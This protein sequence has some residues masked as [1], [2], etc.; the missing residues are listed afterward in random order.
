MEKNRP[1]LFF[2]QKI[3]PAYFSTLRQVRPQ[4]AGV[5]ST[6]KSWELRGHSL[7]RNGEHIEYVP[8][9]K[10]LDQLIFDMMLYYYKVP[11]SILS[12]CKNIRVFLPDTAQQIM[13]NSDKWYF[14]CCAFEHIFANAIRYRKDDDSEITIRMIPE[15]AGALR[16]EVR[17]EGIGLSQ[18]EIDAIMDA[19]IKGYRSQRAIQHSPAGDGVAMDDVHNIVAYLDGSLALEG[20]EN[21]WAK[22]TIVIP[23][24]VEAVSASASGRKK[25]EPLQS[26]SVRRIWC[27]L[28]KQDDRLITCDSFLKTFGVGLSLSEDEDIKGSKRL[29]EGKRR[30]I[31]LKLQELLEPDIYFVFSGKI[32]REKDESLRQEVRKLLGIIDTLGPGRLRD[33]LVRL[34]NHFGSLSEQLLSLQEEERFKRY[35]SF[36]ASIAEEKAAEK[37]A[38]GQAPASGEEEAG[39][40]EGDVLDVRALLRSAPPLLTPEEEEEFLERIKDGD[41][42]ALEY[43][44]RAN[45]RL[46][47][48]LA[49]KYIGAGTAVA[50]F[51]DFVQEGAIELIRTARKFD[52]TKAKRFST[53]ATANV[54]EAVKKA[55]VRNT[56]PGIRVPGWFEDFMRDLARAEDRLYQRRGGRVSAEDIA[57]ELELSIERTQK[58]LS[59]TE[60]ID[61]ATRGATEKSG[62]AETEEEMDSGEFVEMAEARDDT[63]GEA[64]TAE[65]IKEIE[66]AATLFKV[67]D[68]KEWEIVKMH[69]GLCGEEEHIFEE[70]GTR[71][72]LTLQRA[73]QLHKRALKK[74]REFFEREAP[75]PIAAPAPAQPEKLGPAQFSALRQVRGVEGQ[76]LKT[77]SSTSSLPEWMHG[78]VEDIARV[79]KR[80]SK[81]RVRRVT[82]KGMRRAIDA[83]GPRRRAVVIR[84][85][86]ESVELVGIGKQLKPEKPLSRQ[87]VHQLKN[88]ALRDLAEMIADHTID[89]LENMRLYDPRKNRKN[90]KEDVELVCL[91]LMEEKGEEWVTLQDCMDALGKADIPISTSTVQDYLTSVVDK[92]YVERKKDDSPRPVNAKG[93]RKRGPRK[94]IYG[95]T[96]EG[97]QRLRALR[98]ARSNERHPAQAAASGEEVTPDWLL[99]YGVPAEAIDWMARFHKWERDL[100]DRWTGEEFTVLQA[101]A[102]REGLFDPEEDINKGGLVIGPGGSGKTDI[103]VMRALVRCYRQRAAGPKAPKRPVGTVFLVPSKDLAWQLY[104]DLL[105]TY[106]GEDRENGL[107]VRYSDGFF[108]WHDRHIDDGDFD[109]VVMTNEK[110]K[111][112][113]FRR[114]FWANVAEVVFDEADLMSGGGQRGVYLEEMFTAVPWAFDIPIVG[115]TRPC[116]A[117]DIEHALDTIDGDED[118]RFLVQTNEGPVPVRL[119][120][121]DVKNETVVWVDSRTREVSGPEEL[122]LDYKG[123]DTKALLPKLVRLFGIEGDTKGNLM[124][125]VPT[126]QLAVESAQYLSDHAVEAGRDVPEDAG[127]L[128]LSSN[129]GPAVRRLRARL[130]EKRTKDNLLEVVPMGVGFH[131]ADLTTWER[132]EILTAFQSGQVKVLPCTTTLAQGINLRVRGVVLLGFSGSMPDGEG[133]IIFFYEDLLDGL[134]I[135]WMMRAGRLGEDIEGEAIALYVS[136]HGAGSEEY[137]AILEMLR[138]QEGR[139]KGHLAESEFDLNRA[140]LGAVVLGNAGTKHPKP[141]LA[142]IQDC[143][144]GSL[145]GRAVNQ[146]ASRMF[147]AN[148]AASV[149]ALS[150]NPGMPEGVRFLR[151]VRREDG[152]TG[153]ELT[154]FGR[155]I[156]GNG[157]SA[158]TFNALYSWLSERT[159][160][161]YSRRWNVADVLRI[162]QSQT[163]E[164]RNIKPLPTNLVSGFKFDRA[165]EA[166]DKYMAAAEKEL[167]DEWRQ[168]SPFAQAVVSERTEGRERTRKETG[169]LVTLLALADWMQGVPVNE[170][171]KK[172]MLKDCSLDDKAKEFAHLLAAFNDIALRM[173]GRTFPKLEDNQEPEMGKWSVAL[174]YHLRA[175]ADRTLCG[176]PYEATGLLRLD[177]DGF[178]RGAVVKL[179]EHVEDIEFEPDLDIVERIRRLSKNEK[180]WQEAP[181]LQGLRDE[182]E[183]ALRRRS[184]RPIAASL[185]RGLV[186]DFYGVDTIATAQIAQGFDRH[187]GFWIR[188]KR[189]YYVYP[190]RTRADLK[191]MNA[192]ASLV[193]KGAVDMQS[194]TGRLTDDGEF[195]ADELVI[196]IDLKNGCSLDKAK[197]I[198]WEAAELLAGDGRFSDVGIDWTGGEAFHVK[199]RYKGGKFCPIDDVKKDMAEIYGSLADGAFVFTKRQPPFFTKPYVLLDPATSRSRATPRNTFSLNAETG[200]AKVPLVRNLKRD[201][202]SFFR[203]D[204]AVQATPEAVMDTMAIVGEFFEVWEFLQPQDIRAIY[205]EIEDLYIKLSDEMYGGLLEL[206]KEEEPEERRAVEQ[207]A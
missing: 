128:N 178:S 189:D 132:R 10:S 187:T 79:A 71:L 35:R 145:S 68:E 154:E 105:R 53:P 115:I 130:D 86:L 52:R 13:V 146:Q 5:G 122:D 42:E 207:G 29:F 100:D 31:K 109:I 134:G 127:L 44:F 99:G 175:V 139:L 20:V 88:F 143:F 199:G 18:D 173:P 205:R 177:I 117:E 169:K 194:E 51:D 125:G 59:R 161:D 106:G 49:V 93:R 142:E 206:F 190:N 82:E 138:T 39:D 107:N 158:D 179:Y 184:A 182:I 57:A 9:R 19:D 192:F 48:S 75:R 50:D 174:P 81:R 23:E 58:L 12:R 63:E 73:Q 47:V 92:G 90:T 147:S 17:G 97:R 21:E 41:E 67:L 22:A 56:R 140:V 164:G 118:N 2:R 80:G 1:G 104:N 11:A 76:K 136:M 110:F 85:Y 188:G 195:E 157:I 108:H 3:G 37:T 94:S 65:A 34:I 131:N 72:N 198:A 111:S 148:I 201:R 8:E 121:L 165:D 170:I 126:R 24:A 66:R 64:L 27:L 156:Y 91:N 172:Y 114:A 171:E 149:R 84:Y 32:E 77:K 6:L 168:Y 129:A 124:V 160:E 69:H 14:I 204:P 203:F 191:D 186:R 7:Q 123:G 112:F 167:G 4:E 162:A 196:D 102:F 40:V 33:E 78:L 25:V 30:L 103:P 120:L 83:L 133:G 113:I 38:V 141:T 150:E 119:G 176:M 89:E 96:D 98:K 180:L 135:N 26:K 202:E 28:T 185:T 45:F 183:S 43:F 153:F 137:K 101:E 181:I 116:R 61:A 159:H 55:A 62:I 46:L 70:I 16:I 151:Q 144:N 193:R 95:I 152:Q 166:F 197:E 54:R 155:L 87:R 163:S 74:L 60:N 200:G 15:P 36:E